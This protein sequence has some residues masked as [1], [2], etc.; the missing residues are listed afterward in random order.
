MRRLGFIVLSIALLAVMMGTV[1]AQDGVTLVIWG[2]PGTVN[3]INDE[4]LEDAACIYARSLQAGWEE[5]HPDIT[6]QWEDHGWDEALRQNI[7]TAQLGGTA[8]DITVGESFMPEL[9]R[10]GSFLPLAV[11][12]D[13]AANLVPGTVAATTVDGVNHGVAAFTAV[14]ALE[15]NAD[16]VRAAGLDPDTLDV[17]TWD[18]VTEVAAQ[19]NEAGAGEYNGFSILGPTP[20]PAAALFRAAPYIYQTGGDFCDEG[21]VNPTFNDPASI[22]VYEWFRE[23][24]AYTPDGLAFNGDEGFVFTQLF[25]GKTAMQTAGAWHP[26]WARSSGCTDCRYLPLPIPDNGGVAA[27][28]VVG[29]AIYAALADTEHPEE[30]MMFLEYLASDAVQANNFWANGRL[31]ATFSSLEGILAVAGGDTAGVPEYYTGDPV[32]DTAPF[33]TYISELTSENVRTLPAWA[34]K[35]AELNALWNSMFAEVLTSD[36]A[37]EDILNRYQ[38]EAEALIAD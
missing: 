34:E 1:S 35:G 9:T 21:C 25:Q 7:V 30:A 4:S 11:S 19:I 22:P 10:N 18:K 8:P 5:A 24:Y 26:A 32:A 2:E 6:L 3:C 17:S 27:N 31:P 23:L 37:I 14:F 15:V 33:V 36:E 28:V 16:V 29:N 38:A 13:V 20:A 12:D